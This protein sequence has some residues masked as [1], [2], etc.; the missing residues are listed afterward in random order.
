M[1]NMEKLFVY[2]T[3]RPPQPDTPADDSRY[4]LKIAAQI[5]STAPAWLQGRLYHL[6]TYPGLRP[7]QGKVQG[8]LLTV[9]PKAVAIMDRIEGHPTFFKREK[10]TVH[11][12]A[13]TVQA[14][15][16][17]APKGLVQGKPPIASGDWF[18]RH[19]PAEGV[20]L[21][22]AE[23]AENDLPPVDDTLLALVKRF[24]QADCSWLSTVRPDGR[25]HSSPIWHV[26]HNGRAY[27]VTLARA[28]KT[29]NILE[30]PSV[31]ITH[32]DPL[33]PVIIEGWATPAPAMEATL[34]PLFKAKYD[35]D[36]SSDTD[37]DTILEITPLKL[38]AWGK[39]GE[40]R[41]PGEAIMQVQSA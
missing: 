33:N 30:N 18:K 40:G 27:I 25:A 35:W 41:W 29:K 39:Y 31:V 6:G 28:V 32:P 20:D 5:K 2:G 26:W 22:D 1:S 16:Y 34:Q 36:I 3:L 21:P 17:W 7:G 38:M 19:E 15:V 23:E 24:A 10:V 14:W 12:A 13:E 37:Y 11:T 9:T 4:Y 8:D